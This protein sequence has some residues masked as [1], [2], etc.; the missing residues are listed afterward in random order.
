[1][2]LNELT[3]LPWSLEELE[4]IESSGDMDKKT[5]NEKYGFPA[6]PVTISGIDA[7]WV[8]P[9]KWSLPF[10][11]THFGQFKVKGERV[12]E[13]GSEYKVFELQEYFR[14]LESVEEEDPYYLN[15]IHFHAYTSMKDDYEVPDYFNCWYTELPIEKRK[16]NFSWI[17]IGAKNTRS[18][19]HLDIWDTSAWNYLITGVK[20]WLFFDQSQY[21]YLY[22]G[23]VDPFKASLEDYPD[24]AKARPKYCLQYPGDTVFTPSGWWHT[25]LNLETTFSLTENFINETNYKNVLAHF[26]KKKSKQGFESM[27]KIVEE[28]LTI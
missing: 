26:E 24:L 4:H 7:D 6:K 18:G 27:S 19:L 1:M 15:N 10:L 3:K 20:L 16:Y 25:I 11:E 22:E 17:Y 23:K 12:T 14:Y 13:T 9:D 5:F 2:S 28:H 21:P 8:L